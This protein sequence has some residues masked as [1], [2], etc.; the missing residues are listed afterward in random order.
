MYQISQ[1]HKI[2]EMKKRIYIKYNRW[3]NRTEVNDIKLTVKH[4]L[5][6][7]TLDEV[8]IGATNLL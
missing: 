7:P 1:F 5:S 6:K 4:I 8:Y 3:L 2:Q